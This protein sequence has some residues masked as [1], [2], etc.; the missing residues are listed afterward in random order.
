MLRQILEIGIALQ[1]VYIVSQGVM[2]KP[3]VLL[4]YITYRVCSHLGVM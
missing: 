4:K 3:I 2:A 1:G